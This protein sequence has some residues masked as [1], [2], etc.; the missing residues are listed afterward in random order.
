MADA[1]GDFKGRWNG[2]RL[3]SGFHGCSSSDDELSGR[4][5]LTAFNR[6]G[7]GLAWEGDG[8]LDYGEVRAAL[9]FFAAVAPVGDLR[10]CGVDHLS[11]ESARS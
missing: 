5:R 6:N 4:V 3:L 2:F 7:S 8:T 10:I 1:Q 11:G 9:H